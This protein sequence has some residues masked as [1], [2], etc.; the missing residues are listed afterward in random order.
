LN[1]I[2]CISASV[3]ARN[4]THAIAIFIDNRI[5]ELRVEGV[6]VLVHNLVSRHQWAAVTEDSAQYR[7]LSLWRPPIDWI[8]IVQSWQHFGRGSPLRLVTVDRRVRAIEGVHVPVQRSGG[9]LLKMSAD[10]RAMAA[11]NCCNRESCK[12]Y[13]NP[14]YGPTVG[15]FTARGDIRSS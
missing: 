5:E 11:E 12:E 1:Q 8:P 10:L 7:K 14:D 6:V 15:T 13:R 9:I 4:P 2:F 3:H